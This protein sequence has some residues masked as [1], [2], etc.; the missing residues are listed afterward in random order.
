M[1][2]ILRGGFRPRRSTGIPS[3]R[4]YE[5]ASSYGTAIF[6]GDVVNL[7]TAGVVEAA[8][9]GNQTI[10]G[11]VQGCRYVTTDGRTHGGYI[12]ATTVYSP[13]ARGSI[14]ASWVYVWDDPTIEFVANLAAH[15]NT[16]TAAL[17]YAAVGSNMDLVATAGN[18][19]YKRSG[20]QLDGNPIAGAAQFRILEVLRRTANDLTSAN[21]EVVCQINEGFHAFHSSGGI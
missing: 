21:A 18:T 13:T 12:P 15:A 7:V 20:H 4:R 8:A 16:A 9:A 17:I 2:N 3:P 19:V 11:V 6:P 10:M 1:A 14:N 5:V